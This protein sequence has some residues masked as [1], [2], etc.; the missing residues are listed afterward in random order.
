MKPINYCMYLVL[1]YVTKA[2]KW[3]FSFWKDW[4][5]DCIKLERCLMF[6][7]L[8]ERNVCK[9]MLNPT[10]HGLGQQIP[11]DLALRFF[12]LSS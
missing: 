7:N 9:H 5:G 12:L 3:V 1:V 4:S 11:A 6:I 10:E 8:L 2:H